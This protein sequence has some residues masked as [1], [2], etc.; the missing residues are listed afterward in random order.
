MT[1]GAACIR[2]ELKVKNFILSLNSPLNSEENPFYHES[3]GIIDEN[4]IL[5]LCMLKHHKM[6]SFVLG[7]PNLVSV[8]E[9]DVLV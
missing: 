8:K 2:L 1:S 6:H 9:F 4:E 7:S 5:C 3:K